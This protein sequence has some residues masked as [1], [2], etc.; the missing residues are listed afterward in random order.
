MDKRLHIACDAS[1]FFFSIIYIIARLSIS[2]IVFANV[3][4]MVHVNYK[5]LYVS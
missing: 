4:C 3:W 2:L 5:P 1:F